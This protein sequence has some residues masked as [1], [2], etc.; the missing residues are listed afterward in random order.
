MSL[1]FEAESKAAAERKATQAGMS[2][3]RVE[4]VTSGYPAKSNAPNP[5]AGRF[6]SRRRRLP[7]FFIGVVLGILI[8]YFRASI[9]H[10][11]PR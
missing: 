3:H 7:L 5:R 11:L 8:W 4:D 1:E 10:L 9:M 6:R 2:V